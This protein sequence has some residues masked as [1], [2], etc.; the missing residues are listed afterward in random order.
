MGSFLSGALLQRTIEDMAGEKREIMRRRLFI[1][2]AWTAA[3]IG[4]VLLAGSI[5]QRIGAAQD[6]KDY[7]PVGRMIDVSGKQMHLYE[8]GEGEVTVVMTSGW[9][10][11]QPY[12]DYYPLYE[13]LT[14]HAKV[15]VY[16]RF[17]T[18]FSDVTDRKRHVDTIVDEVHELLEASGQKPPYVLVA[19]S[20]GSLE[21]VR[22]AQRY[23][24]EV[25]GMVMIDAGTPEYYGEMFPITAIAHVQRFLVDTGIVRLLAQRDSFM[26]GLND[27]M[28]ALRL[29]PEALRELDRKATLLVSNS[30]SIRDE[31]RQSRANAKVV[32]EAGKKLKAPIVALT[33]GEFG[34]G[35]DDIWLESQKGW[36][37]WS[38]D[39]RQLVVRDAHHYV[40]QYEPELVA[41]EILKL[42]ELR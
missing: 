2:M 30:R 16:D 5:Y 27:Q 6:K 9:G 8:E 3:V 39:A 19:H 1:I 41:D 37:S 36:E 14:A 34:V 22:Y 32:L 35:A 12:V 28:N 15:V 26:D 21:T 38:A 11:V 20:M 29:V 42:V 31:M 10:T 25:Q 7:L 33:A 13:R 17:G 4:V 24:E 23:P 18:G 40:H